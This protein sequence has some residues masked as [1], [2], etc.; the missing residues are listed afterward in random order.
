MD[1]QNKRWATIVLGSLLMVASSG[2]TAV[3]PSAPPGTPSS[4][5]AAP[6][7]SALKT[8]LGE[9]EE[10]YDARIGLSVTDTDGGS[11]LDYQGDSR[12]GYASTLK[13]LAAAALLDQTT[14]EQLDR[15]ITWSEA[16]VLESGYSPVTSEHIDT[17]LPLG[18]VAMARKT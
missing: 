18:D 14:P 7:D 6:A 12:F 3:E 17:G 10:Q 13:T 15:V 11:T 16:D 4:A 5:S 2:C 1:T 8:A 9:L